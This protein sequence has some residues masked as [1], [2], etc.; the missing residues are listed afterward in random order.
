MCCYVGLQLDNNDTLGIAWVPF[1]SE[2]PPCYV[3]VTWE[4]LSLLFSFYG[5]TKCEDEKVVSNVWCA[6]PF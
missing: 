4:M 1:C 3:M 5:N 2:L 6:Q